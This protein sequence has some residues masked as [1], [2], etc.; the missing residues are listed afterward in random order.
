MLWVIYLYGQTRGLSATRR[1][2]SSFG[3]GAKWRWREQRR[4]RR[5][6]SGDG[7]KCIG[8]VVVA[9][10]LMKSSCEEGEEDLWWGKGVILEV[11]APRHLEKMTPLQRGGV[12]YSFIFFLF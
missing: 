8:G 9:H 6:G 2:I 5:G 4:G 3:L 12:T 10:H 7:V 1:A 11:E